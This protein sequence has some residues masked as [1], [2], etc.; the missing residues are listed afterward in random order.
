MK[1]ILLILLLCISTL[2]AEKPQALLDS[3]SQHAI[4][5]GSGNITNVYV[6]VDPMCVH[7][8]DYVGDITHNKKLHEKNSYYIFLYRLEKFDS[9]EL[10]QFIY[11]AKNPKSALEDIM[12]ENKEVDTFDLDVSEKTLKVIE[13]VASVGEQLKADHRPF[14]IRLPSLTTP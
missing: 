2:F 11:Q 14:I 6:F 10:I 3:I 12:I 1:N 4:R 5:I 8:Q 9:D 7:S 13:E